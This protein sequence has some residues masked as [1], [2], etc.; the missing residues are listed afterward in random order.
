MIW[1]K[2]DGKKTVCLTFDDG[3]IPEVTPHILRILEEKNVKAT[4][5]VVGEN[6]DK[7]PD[8]LRAIVDAG[9]RVGN[10][11]YHHIKGLKTSC[12]AYLSDAERCQGSIDALVGGKAAEG[13]RLFR[14]PYGR[15][16]LSQKRALQ[17]RGYT[18]VLWDVLTHDYNR[19]FSQRKMLEV[20]RKYTRHGSVVVFH[21]SL[22][23]GDRMLATLPLAIDYWR[24]QGCEFALL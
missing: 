9:H 6:V 4:F 3:P 7:H 2:T 18:L 5:F 15:F 11:T 13:V 17:K 14:P 24:E 23:S 12:E 16:T 20:V 19:R 1:R 8:L 22:K 21:D 10:H